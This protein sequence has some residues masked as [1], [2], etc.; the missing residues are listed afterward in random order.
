MFIPLYLA[1]KLNSS[2][3]I[4]KDPIDWEWIESMSIKCLNDH[5]VYHW[6]TTNTDMVVCVCVRVYL[7]MFTLSI[8]LWNLVK[9]ERAFCEPIWSWQWDQLIQLNWDA[10]VF[11]VYTFTF[12]NV[13]ELID[14]TIAG[15]NHPQLLANDVEWHSINVSNSGWTSERM[16]KRATPLVEAHWMYWQVLFQLTLFCLF[17]F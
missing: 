4:H 14:C 13:N 1:V 17:P 9:M 11:Y 8:R 7:G 12:E 15:R 2:C 10:V 16:N 5:F 6:L 3:K